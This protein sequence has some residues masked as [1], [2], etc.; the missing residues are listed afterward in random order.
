MELLRKLFSL[1]VESL[2]ATSNLIK[3]WKENKQKKKPR[4]AF[5]S[6]SA[7]DHK[8]IVWIAGVQKCKPRVTLVREA[9][10]Q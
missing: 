3:Q 1:E 6:Q 2:I 4:I 5:Q 8:D 7:E 10:L 9:D